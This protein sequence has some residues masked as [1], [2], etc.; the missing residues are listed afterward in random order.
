MNTGEHNYIDV[1]IESKK[2][3]KTAPTRVVI[4]PNFRAE[5]EMA[6]ASAE[7]NGL[8]NSLTE[9]FVGNVERLRSVIKIMCTAA[10]KCM[11]DNKMHMAPWR[12]HK[13]MQSKWLGTCERAMPSLVLSLSSSTA[14]GKSMMRPRASMLTFDLHCS[15][16]AVKVL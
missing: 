8:V 11:K 15:S 1:V 6:R 10:K 4:E 5:F 12:K 2:S 13:Y 9:I 7:Y 3:T 14:Q 16:T